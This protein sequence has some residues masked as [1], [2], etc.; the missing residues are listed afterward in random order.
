MAWVTI[1]KVNAW[2]KLFYTLRSSDKNQFTFDQVH[3]VGVPHFISQCF[4]KSMW[5][6]WQHA[7]NTA[8]TKSRAVQ[9]SPQM[10]P[11]SNLLLS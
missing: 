2:Y 4:A 8:N 9:R 10:A 6:I 5:Y 1:L 7:A 3:T 11:D